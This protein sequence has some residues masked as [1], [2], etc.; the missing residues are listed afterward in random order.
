MIKQGS[1]CPFCAGVTKGTLED[2]KQVASRRGGRCLS[3][4]YINSKA[5][6]LWQCAEGHQWK[7][8]PNHVKRG[9]WCPECAKLK[10]FTK[11][12]S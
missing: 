6:L 4:E 8:S 2:M 5:K 3:N 1:W 9:S 10:R 12:K 11:K 7:A